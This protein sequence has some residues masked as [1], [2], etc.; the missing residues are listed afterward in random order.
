MAKTRVLVHHPGTNHLAYE[1]VAALQAG[2]YD[3]DFHT[4]VFYAPGSALARTLAML[5]TALRAR[6][7]REWPSRQRI[8]GDPGGRMETGVDSR[9]GAG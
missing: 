5:P 6:A 4:G 9:P 2:G 3:C 1:L 7:E 8:H